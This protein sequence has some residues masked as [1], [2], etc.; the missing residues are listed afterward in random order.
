MTEEEVPMRGL[1]SR[2][3][4]RL[5]WWLD[6]AR[7][8]DLAQLEAEQSSDYPQ[9]RARHVR[10]LAGAIKSA[11]ERQVERA[12]RRFW[13][14]AAAAGIALAASA[15]GLHAWLGDEPTT[16]AVDDD[17]ASLRRVVGKVIAT[18]T[19][20]SN[21]IVGEDAR[22]A[23][24]TEVSTAGQ[25]S[26]SLDA[27]RARVDLSSATTLRLAQL[28]PATQVFDLE[29]G[30]VD[31]SVPKVPG[32]P[33]I[34][35]VRTSDTIVTVHGTV[36]SVEV[37]QVDDKPIT[38]VGVTRG[39][40]SVK[41]AG[42]EVMLRPGDTWNSA[43]GMNPAQTVEANPDAT[44]QTDAA[45]KDEGASAAA[46]DVA[47]KVV[48]RAS[49]PKAPAVSSDLAE[50]NRLFSQ[51][52]RARDGGDDKRAVATLERLLSSYP[53]SPLRTTAQTELAAAKKRLSTRAD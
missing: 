16:V 29:V 22:I 38:T 7:S 5:D 15:T 28:D 50:Q 52:L 36:F 26:A 47:P 6:A 24:G 13:T 39:L 35:R 37:N 49:R 19:D 17:S 9:R 33:R 27:D 1:T 11:P 4:E 34:I 18:S 40:V 20:G 21:A 23:P 51:A 10:A 8:A 3:Q 32:E 45:D 30:R 44:E 14:F 43:V 31:V 46:D 53:N 41:H 12:S 42:V 48:V 2:D 25:A